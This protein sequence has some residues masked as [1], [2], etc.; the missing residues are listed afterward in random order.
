MN[1]EKLRGIFVEEAREIIAKL[2]NDIINELFRGVHTLKGSARS[3]GFENLGCFAHTLENLLDHYRS[4]K[5]DV[6]AESIDICLKGIDI[7]KELLEREIAG[8]ASLPEGYKPVLASIEALHSECALRVQ[9]PSAAQKDLASEFALME[10]LA[11]AAGEKE[12]IEAMIS[13]LDGGERLYRIEVRLPPQPLSRGYDGVNEALLKIGTVWRSEWDLRDVPALEEFD[14]ERNYIP[15]VTYYVCCGA[16]DADV[17][18]ALSFLEEKERS[19]ALLG[20]AGEKPPGEKT[21]TGE[22]AAVKPVASQIRIDTEKLDILFNTIGELVIAQNFLIE[23]K[24]LYTL[25]NENIIRALESLSKIT[26][27]LEKHVTALRMV[28]VQATFEKMKRIAYDAGKGAGK[29]VE[30]ILEGVETEI[31]KTM[32]DALSDPLVH[33]IRN[34]VDHGIESAEKRLAAGKR[35]EGSVRLKAFQRGGSVVVEVSDDGGGIDKEAVRS[36]ATERGLI[37][38][39]IIPKDKE[40][41][42]LLLLP[43]FST[44]ESVS[45]LSGRGVGLDVVRTAVSKLHGRVEIDSVAGEGCTVSLI[46]PLTLAIIDGMVV[47]N[48]EGLF[49][50]PTLSVRETFMIDPATIHTVRGEGRFVD[51]RGT[52]IPVVRLETLLGGGVGAAAEPLDRPPTY[53]LVAS[54]REEYAIE[55]DEIINRQQVVIKP[56]GAPLDALREI[57]GGAILGSGEIAFIL[58]VEKLYGAER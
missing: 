24:A 47:K 8:D 34:A 5:L 51:L 40:L 1:I 44:S 6:P 17:S 13:R 9:T 25:E 39:T 46:L 18:R 31:D 14:P 41:Y 7:L 19:I 11:P 38:K 30:L 50:I 58:N 10:P 15:K 43:G 2:E 3:F 49:I 57:S 48:G 12:D 16:S 29:E 23:N 21:R 26:R 36:R 52:M 33:M 4:E 54:E 32:I 35:G 20:R 22:T 53:I 55:V 37:A 42:E 28:P 56:L 27:R 45:E